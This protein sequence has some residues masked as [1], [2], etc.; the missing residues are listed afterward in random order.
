[1]SN[2]EK[3]EYSIQERYLITRIAMS[4]VYTKN[5][6][7][8]KLMDKYKLSKSKIFRYLKVDLPNISPLLYQKVLKVNEINKQ[9]SYDQLAEYNKSK[10][11]AVSKVDIIETKLMKGAE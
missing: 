5:S 11:C 6:S 2:T 8:Q 3:P 10:R 4:Y 7:Y 9:R 1:M